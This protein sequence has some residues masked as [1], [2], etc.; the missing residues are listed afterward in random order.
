MRFLSQKGVA[1]NIDDFR[2]GL[3]YVSLVTNRGGAM[4]VS[5]QRRHY[6]GKDGRERIYETHLLRRS[7]RQDGKAKNETVAN[8][9]QLPAATIEV[10]RASLAGQALVPA[11]AAATVTRAF[12]H[13]HVA[14]VHAVARSLGLPGLLGPPGRARDLALALVIARVVRPASKLATT[15]W[16]ADTT[17]GVDLGVADASTD[18]VYAA[19]DALLGRQDTIEAALAARHLAPGVNPAR[20]ALFDLTSAWM[21]GKHCPL[22]AYGHSRDGKKG[23]PQIE[24]GLLTDPAGRPVAV[25][26][27]P[28]NTADPA[29]FIAAVEMVRDTFALT[30][31]VMVGDRGM[32]TSAR[33]E[34]LRADT[35]LGWLTALRAPAIAALAAEDGPLQL[36]LFD[37][38][39]LAEI[40]HPDYPN[41]RLIACRNPLLAADRARKR[42][43]LLAATDTVLAP[44]QAAVREGRLAGADQIGL[45]VGRVVNKFKMAK[46]LK[47]TITNTALT[48][49]RRQDQIDAE[50]ALDGIYVL[51]TSVPATDLDAPAV[52]AAYKNLANVEREFRTIKVDDLHLRPIHHRLEDRVRAHVLIAML[53]A[54][55]VWHLRR[56]W[57]PLTFTDTEPPERDNPVAPAKRSDAATAK[58]SRK[59]DA[60][61]QPVRSFRALLDHLATLTRNDIRYGR[62]DG[63]TVPTLAQ[64]T[65]TQRRAFALLEVPIPL[66]LAAK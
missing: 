32:I 31:L 37:E 46:H 53:A 51:R 57:A 52:V 9:S 50:A 18:E 2:G 54:Y 25:R 6:V 48:I 40:T 44:L 30:D 38:F 47:V 42:G 3:R 66:H 8:L 27:F 17:L 62:S 29:A 56:A 65:D 23:L 24:Y 49:E 33:I 19:M 15:S 35:D 14:A 55:L 21:T 10:I 45:K 28:G 1:T 60:N 11:A 43:E 4:H 63:P 39:D 41:E 12:P 7:Y 13:G 16:W 36:S 5:T 58:A 59:R 22:A 64:P 34:A 20:M 26:V 61:D